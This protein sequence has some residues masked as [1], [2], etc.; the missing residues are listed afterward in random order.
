MKDWD[1]SIYRG[2]LTGYNEAFII[3]EETKNR[4]I[5]AS[6]KNAEIIRP[7]LRGKDIHRYRC[8]EV[9][10]W[11][12]FIPWHFPL[13]EDETIKGVSFEAEKMFREHYPEVYN[14]L[15]SH[16]T[17]LEGRN[18][19]ETGIR[20]EWYAL[21]RYGAN[22]WKEFEKVKIVWGNLSLRG[23]YSL[24]MEGVFVNAPSTFIPS[25]N[26]YLLAILNS[27][28]ADFYIKQLGVT[29]NG[30]YFEYK[31]MFIEQ[32]PVPTLSEEKENEFVELVKQRLKPNSNGEII[33]NEIDKKAIGLFGLTNEEEEFIYN[34][35]A[36]INDISFGDRANKL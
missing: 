5:K 1:I 3:D 19:A 14:Y 30:G 27:I 2:I 6:P 4:L 11:I 18:K 25:G 10:Q 23:S 24:A 34:S 15:L 31:P 32:L 33:D 26:L 7:I 17:L 8:D 9:D 22:Y 16:K 13:H 29:R 35:A 12:I 20:Y 28:I 21:Q 36:S